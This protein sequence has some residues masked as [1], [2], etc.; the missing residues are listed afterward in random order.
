MFEAIVI[1][2]LARGCVWLERVDNH[3]S[4]FCHVSRVRDNRVLHVGDRVKFA[5]VIENPRNPGKMMADDVEYIGHLI[6][7]QVSGNGGGR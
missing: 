2:E 6:T 7:R 4:I 1:S 5:S 3:S